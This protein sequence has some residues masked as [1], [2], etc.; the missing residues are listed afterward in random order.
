MK[1]GVVFHGNILAGGCFQQSLTAIKLLSTDIS[2]HELIYY[3]PDPINAISAKDAGISVRTFKFGRKERLVH[4]IRK[5][6]TLNRILGKFAFFQPFD[7]IFEKDGVDLLY[8]TG[9]SPI[10]LFLEKLN[11][12]LTFWD[13][14]HRDHVEFP[15][16]RQGFEFE[17]RENFARNALPKATAVI[18]ESPLGKQNL[19]RRYGLDNDRVH[20]IS[21]SP[22][23]RYPE[24][25]DSSFDPRKA[26]KIP[27]DAPYIFYPA[28]LWAHK[29]HRLIIDSLAYLRN[30][31]EI[32]IFAVFCGSDCGN[33][34]T[35]LKMA[36]RKGVGDLV[37]YMGF[38]PD[39]QMPAFY[40]NSLALV[41]PSYFGPTNIPPLEAFAMETPVVV[42]NLPGIRDQVG[43]AAL[44]VSPENAES[45]SDA[46]GRL[47]NEP[48]LRNIFIEKG[49]S[50]LREFSDK[51]RLTT[52]RG[53]FNAYDRKRLTWSVE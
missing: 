28:Q 3:T 23:Q 36:N 7:A 30:T 2:K 46:I 18:A 47:V 38:I 15:E 34:S 52:L 14:C 9:P 4:K 11:Y 33:S 32:E 1:I 31:R 17:A 26:A 43:N 19:E 37:K 21:L 22:A 40:K 39:E 41:M 53:I 13:L 35:M 20:W 29:N 6:I 45:L 25:E 50:R 27:L 5:Q 42:S 24:N 10:C 12:I 49:K 51:D 16:V 44:L 8:F 48:Q